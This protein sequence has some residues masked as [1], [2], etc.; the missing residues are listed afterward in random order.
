MTFLSDLLFA[1]VNSLFEAILVAPINILV[2]IVVAVA[3]G[4][5]T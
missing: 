4:A 1:L 3:S 5:L 2:D